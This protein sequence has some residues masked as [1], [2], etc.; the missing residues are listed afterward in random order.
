MCLSTARGESMCLLSGEPQNR[1]PPKSRFPS[2]QNSYRATPTVDGRNPAPLAKPWNDVCPVNTS[3]QRFQPWFSSAAK[4][5]C[6][7]TV[8]MWLWLKIQDL[9]LR[10]LE[11]TFPFVFFAPQAGAGRVLRRRLPGLE[12][13][14]RPWLFGRVQRRPRR[15]WGAAAPEPSGLDTVSRESAR[16]RGPYTYMIYF[17]YVLRWSTIIVLLFCLW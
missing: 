14:L 5:I 12:N 3:K 6:P 2:L 9:G 17:T 11:S 13:H 1:A 4:W 16:T 15:L 7:S 8:S 10:G